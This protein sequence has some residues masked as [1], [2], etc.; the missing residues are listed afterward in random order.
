MALG[1][2]QFDMPAPDF[3]STPAE[4][5]AAMRDL[6]K[7][8]ALTYRELEARAQAVGDKLP[9]GLIPSLMANNDLPRESTLASFVRACAGEHAVEQWLAVRRRIAVGTAVSLADQVEA[10]LTGQARRAAEFERSEAV[11]QWSYADGRLAQAVASASGD[12]WVG[13]HRRRRGFWPFGRRGV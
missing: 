9:R 6:R 2:R 4:L 5:L 3:A 8:A 11:A 13:L 1:V 12:K 10:W 7:W